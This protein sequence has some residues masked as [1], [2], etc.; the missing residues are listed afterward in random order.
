MVPRSAKKAAKDLIAQQVKQSLPHVPT[1]QEIKA[2]IAAEVKNSLAPKP[3]PAPNYGENT[4]I[5]HPALENSK[6][7][8]IGTGNILYCDKGVKLTNSLVHFSGNNSLI[9]LSNGVDSRYSSV[10]MAIRNNSTIYVG[11]GTNFN[12][13]ID[14]KT[15]LSIS[16][17]KNLIIGNDCMFSFNMWVT[18]SDAHAAFDTKTRQRFNL[19]KSVLIG[20]HV[21]VGQDV[22]ILKG[23]QIGSGS[24]IGANSLLAGKTLQSNAVYA[25]VPVKLVR[26]DTFYDRPDIQLVDK[27]KTESSQAEALK[28]AFSDDNHAKLRLD[29]IDK[30]LSAAKTSKAKLEYVKKNLVANKDKNR[31]YI[32]DED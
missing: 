6:I 18:T 29:Q 4:V 31:F 24:I 7:V 26:P 12:V 17:C 19:P 32:S 20:D 8:F 22:T 3:K 14:F 5:N 15:N 11:S 27:V 28:A 13:L 10:H 25:G 30:S 21:W 23:T 9:Y 1:E 16:E 2:L